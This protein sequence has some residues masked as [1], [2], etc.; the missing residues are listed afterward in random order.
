MKWMFLCF[1]CV[2]KREADR[3]VLTT[4]Q[5]RGAKPAT[6]HAIAA[7][8]G[9]KTAN[10]VCFLSHSEAF[11]HKDHVQVVFHPEIKIRE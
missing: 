6:F 1:V 4:C 3:V 5:Q 11:P 7:Q 8:L 9:N 2:I 10:E